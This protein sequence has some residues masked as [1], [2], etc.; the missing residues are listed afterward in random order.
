MFL[1]SCFMIRLCPDHVRLSHV[2]RRLLST[3]S[4]TSSASH[5]TSYYDDLGV[6]PNSTS[7]EIKEAFYKLSKEYHPDKN[8]GNPEALQKFQVISEAYDLLS[9]PEKRIKY[10]KGVL[11]RNSSVAEREAASHRFEGEN[12]Y[13]ARGS[14][15]IHRSKD[16]DRNLDLWVTENRKE[17]FQAGLAQKQYQ[18]NMRKRNDQWA[19]IS[20]KSSLDKKLSATSAAGNKDTDSKL[21]FIG[22]VFLLLVIIT[23]S[24]FL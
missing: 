20:G 19:G 2:V 4:T 13:G 8:I 17:S 12:F 22:F 10:D 18:R 23:R 5:K 6:V 11:G 16:L 7:R 14:L 15:K 9:N 1:T 24:L 3:S 21:F